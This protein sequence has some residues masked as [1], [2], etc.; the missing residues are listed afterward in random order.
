MIVDLLKPEYINFLVRA[1][2]QA[3]KYSTEERS[4]GAPSYALHQGKTLKDLIDIAIFLV[5]K[6]D[7]IVHRQSLENSESI[8]RELRLLREIIDKNWVRLVGSLALK[9]L[10]LKKSRNRTKKLLP[11]TED[12]MRLRTHCLEKAR[13]A[14]NILNTDCNPVE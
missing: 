6:K 2:K 10:N 7:S 4:Y 11:L 5:C 3:S 8:L 1:S 13:R 12:V 14:R 9:E